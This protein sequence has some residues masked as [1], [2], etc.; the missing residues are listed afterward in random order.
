MSCWRGN[1]IVQVFGDYNGDS[2]TDILLVRGEEMTWAFST[3]MG[4][5]V[6]D[7]FASRSGWIGNWKISASQSM[8]AGDWFALGRDMVFCHMGTEVAVLDYNNGV[9]RL[10]WYEDVT[11]PNGALEPEPQEG[12]KIRSGDRFLPVKLSES[13]RD[14]IVVSDGLDV[15]VLSA[16]GREAE[17]V[18]G[19]R[20]GEALLLWTRGQNALVREGRLLRSGRNSFFIGSASALVEVIGPLGNARVYPLEVDGVILP[21]A[22]AIAGWTLSPNDAMNRTD[23][24]GDGIQEVVLRSPG[25]FAIVRW[26]DGGPKVSWMAE[27]RIGEDWT[28]SE[29]DRLL[30]GELVIARGGQELLLTNGEAWLVLGW[31]SEAE[32]LEVLGRAAGEV[33]AG[34]P[35]TIR[36]GQRIVLGRFLPGMEDAILAHD[37]SSPAPGEPGPAD[38]PSLVV[39]R[40]DGES[41]SFRGEVAAVRMLGEWTLGVSDSL[42]PA[43][44]DDDPEQE[45]FIQRGSL[46]G[47]LDFTLGSTL[48]P[49]STF[50]G[51]MKDDV[52]EFTTPARFKRGDANDDGGVDISDAVLVLGSLFR[53]RTPPECID[54]AD[55]DDSGKVNVTDPLFILGFLFT[56]GPHPPPPGPFVQGVDFSPDDLGCRGDF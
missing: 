20:A 40:F 47:V 29:R 6:I 39:A 14:E 8:L 33:T 51:R 19:W 30:H 15:G 1:E 11:I 55:A 27:E 56:S 45:V 18:A 25:R 38:R 49:R 32:T 7:S 50:V 21:Q 31:N 4:K 23:L 10:S 41:R 53:G 12:W 24:D 52:L 37:G 3:G 2:L 54:A 22:G 43:N 36:R 5:L 16:S 9:P 34:T 48:A 35:F 44:T 46:F 17:M 26:V 13:G 28:L 42:S